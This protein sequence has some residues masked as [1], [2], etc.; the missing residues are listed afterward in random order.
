M[1]YRNRVCPEDNQNTFN[2][3]Y[4]VDQRCG[5]VTIA[6]IDFRLS[7]YSWELYIQELHWGTPNKVV[8][9]KSSVSL[10]RKLALWS[11]YIKELI[12]ILLSF[13][14]FIIHHFIVNLTN[15]HMLRC[16][17]SWI[18]TLVFSRERRGNFYYC[19]S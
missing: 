18:H 8:Y 4:I 2:F 12:D 3:W 10:R 1:K 19:V 5:K 16:R 7:S 17:K 9:L 13:L 15:P 6:V 11:Y 14:Y